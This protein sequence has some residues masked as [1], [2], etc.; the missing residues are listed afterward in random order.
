MLYNFR[1]IDADNHFDIGGIVSVNEVFFS[2]HV[3][4]GDAYCTYFV[5]GKDAKPEFITPF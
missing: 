1:L 4:G 5:E 2:K 3:S